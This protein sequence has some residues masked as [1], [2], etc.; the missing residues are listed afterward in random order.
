[1]FESLIAGLKQ[2]RDGLKVKD[3]TEIRKGFV[4]VVNSIDNVWDR[5]NGPPLMAEGASH[6]AEM[7]EA[8]LLAN[9]CLELLEAP[10]HPA[11][12]AAEMSAIGDGKFL[13][14]VKLLLPIV[15]KF[16]V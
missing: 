16:I 15:L 13:G 1:M 3:I 11:M 10:D 2:L 14:L 6:A 7:G 8:R 12:N 4:A 5:F 9:E